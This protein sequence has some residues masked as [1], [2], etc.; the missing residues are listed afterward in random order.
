M[1]SRGPRPALLATP[2]DSTEC[3]LLSYMLVTS[4][5]LVLFGR[6]GDLIGQ[7]R[8]YVMGFALFGMSSIACALAPA[9]WALIAARAVQGLGSAML[10]SSR[11]AIGL[12]GDAVAVGLSTG[13]VLGG[14]IVTYSDW[15][16]D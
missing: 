15:T 11:R 6:L 16:R 2:T 8:V 12:N 9:F 7:K 5:T 4:S 10:M 13:P 1:P 14:L 3:V